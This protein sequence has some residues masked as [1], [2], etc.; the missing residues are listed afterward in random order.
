M[1]KTIPGILDILEA[2]GAIITDGHVVLTSGKHSAGYINLRKLAGRRDA[3]ADVGE[4]IS[5]NIHKHT[6]AGSKDILLVGPETMGRNLAQEVAHINGN[7]Y[8][9]CEPNSDKTAMQ[10]NQ[11]L[12]FEEVIKGRRCIILDDVLTTAQSL[13]QTINLIRS[14]GGEV[15]GA[16]VIIR[17][18]VEISAGVLGIPWLESLQDIGIPAYNAEKCP[19]CAEKKPIW[20]HPGHGYEWIKDHPDYPTK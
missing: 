14:S 12:D 11:K 15:K 9:W 17:R 10:W 6:N 5:Q 7:D 4:I 18:N 8:V 19:L 20:L 1:S 2:Q 13:L 3:M 16:V